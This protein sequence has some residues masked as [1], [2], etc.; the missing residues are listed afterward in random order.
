[1]LTL[2]LGRKVTMIPL[3]SVKLDIRYISISCLS[4]VTDVHKY[5][6]LCDLFPVVDE[7]SL[8]CCQ[9]VCR[10]GEVI[11]VKVLG[12]MALIDEGL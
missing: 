11:Q 7:R 4:S 6:S 9:Q 3:M 12:I 2:T 8:Q 1:M 5:Y 10:R